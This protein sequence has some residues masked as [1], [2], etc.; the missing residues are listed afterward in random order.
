M[1]FEAGVENVVAE[2]SSF[3]GLGK[4]FF[5]EGVGLGIFVAEVDKSAGGSGGEGG[6]DHAFDQ[7][8]RIVVHEDAI[9]EATG[10]AFVGIADDGLGVAVAVGNGFPF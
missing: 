8:E 1:E 7:C 9:L 4:A 3:A 10:F 6:D 5:E 2:E